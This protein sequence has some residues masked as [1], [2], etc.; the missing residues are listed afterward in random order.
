MMKEIWIHIK[1]KPPDDYE[2]LTQGLIMYPELYATEE[3]IVLSLSLIWL[4]CS[5]HN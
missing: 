4:L 3:R 1:L 2:L 5:W